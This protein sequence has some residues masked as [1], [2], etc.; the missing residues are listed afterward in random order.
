MRSRLTTPSTVSSASLHGHAP[1]YPLL[2]D[3][4]PSSTNGETG[5]C[6][7]CPRDE[8]GWTWGRNHKGMMRCL[9]LVLLFFVFAQGQMSEFSSHKRIFKSQ[10]TSRVKTL[11]LCPRS[12]TGLVT[13]WDIDALGMWVGVIVVG[14]HGLRRERAKCRNRTGVGGS[15]DVLLVGVP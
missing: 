12:K 9:S 14:V 11:T 1:Q 2:G 3:V 7:A 13:R 8:K 15:G 6:R 4:N 10:P 5:R